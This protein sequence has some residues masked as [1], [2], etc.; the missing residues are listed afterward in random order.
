MLTV[1]RTMG[2]RPEGTA[3]VF[4]HLKEVGYGGADYHIPG[5]QPGTGIYAMPEKEFLEFVH[6]DLEAA[7]AVGIPV[8]QAHGPWPYDDRTPEMRELKFQATVRALHAAAIM[9]SPYLVIHPTLP[10]GWLMSPSAHHEEHKAHNIAFLRSMIPYAR[11][12]GIKIALENMP[13]P[14]LACGH[15]SELVECIDTIDSEYVMACL[16][17]GHCTCIGDDSGEMVRLLGNRLACL[18]VHD[19]DGMRDAH[20]LPYFGVMNWESFIEGLRAVKYR[21]NITLEN[22]MPTNMPASLYREL[23]EWLVRL[24]QSIVDAVMKK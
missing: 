19:N 11:D 13:N 22:D 16:D 4:K 8:C 18:H 14:H 7:K 5:S 2:M 1:Q 12:F 10:E 17:T 9:G 23:E 3:R 6:R 20:F 24:A 15:V 21:G